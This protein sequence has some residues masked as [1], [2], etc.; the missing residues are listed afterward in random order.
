[1]SSPPQTSSLTPPASTT[2]AI[3]DEDDQEADAPLTMAAS[4]VLTSLP[5][6]SKKALEGAGDV[7]VDKGTRYSIMMRI[8]Q[9][10]N[11]IVCVSWSSYEHTSCSPPDVICSTT[12]GILLSHSS[13]YAPIF[14]QHGLTLRISN[15]PISS[16]P[17][18]PGTAAARIQSLL[19]PALRDGRPLPTQEVGRH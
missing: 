16:A 3:P 17:L 8:F 9:C 18:S 19:A 7:G 11:V 6:D 2:A 10:L 14:T 4:V 12:S 15:D 5:R 1:M 13:P